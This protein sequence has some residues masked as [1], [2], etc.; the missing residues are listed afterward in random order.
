MESSPAC[1]SFE[2]N[3][4]ARFGGEGYPVFFCA[5][6]WNDEATRTFV[7]YAD[8]IGVLDLFVEEGQRIDIPP[9]R[10]AARCVKKMF[11]TCSG[12][13]TG[14]EQFR[15]TASMDLF[16]SF[17][18][19]G[20]DFKSFSNLLRVGATVDE[21]D[22]KFVDDLFA[23]SALREVEFRAPYTELDCRR[24]GARP[25]LASVTFRGGPLK[26]LRGLESCAR[27][28]ELHLHGCSVFT[29]LGDLTRFAGLQSLTLE[30][31]P[32]L[33]WETNLTQFGTLKVLSLNGLRTITGVL[34]LE[35]LHRLERLRIKDCPNAVMDLAAVG[36]M[37]NLQEIW[38]NRQHINLDLE[39]LFALPHLEKLGAQGM[40]KDEL[41][42]LVERH[43][44]KVSG[45]Q[46]FGRVTDPSMVIA[47]ME[48]ASGE[49]PA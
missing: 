45:W 36:E 39:T 22:R 46:C 34:S 43:G 2:R 23:C 9:L 7:T 41:N 13:I 5:N 47:T 42:T 35:G 40:S 24:F 19:N 31:L 1:S 49:Y 32:S 33:R 8:E 26:S 14:L 38:L 21:S 11:I 15:Q 27:L 6:G 4:G 12:A 10:E 37:A 29:D 25:E 30:D 20:I 18:T 48:K 17:P 44:R 16:R 28:E 3:Y